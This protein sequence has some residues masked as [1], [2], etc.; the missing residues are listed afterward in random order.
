ML[1][2]YSEQTL[3]VFLLFEKGSRVSQASFKLAV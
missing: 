1:F 2:F 3:N